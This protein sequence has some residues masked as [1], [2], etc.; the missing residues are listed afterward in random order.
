[1]YKICCVYYLL[2]RLKRGHLTGFTQ[3]VTFVNRT[4]AARGAHDRRLLLRLSFVPKGFVNRDCPNRVRPVMIYDV[5]LGETS[6]TFG[7]K[8]ATAKPYRICTYHTTQ[9]YKH[10]TDPQIADASS[11]KC[12]APPA[13]RAHPLSTHTAHTTRGVARS[14]AEE[15]GR[16]VDDGVAPEGLLHGHARDAHHG[17]APILDLGDLHGVHVLG[18]AHAVDGRLARHERLEREG[19]RRLLRPGQAHRVEAVVAADAEPLGVGLAP[20]L[21]LEEGERPEDDH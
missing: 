14:V 12:T 3:A 5:S 10:E 18:V 19:A 9:Q 20:G 15:E 17:H 2:S 4:Q 8:R 1:M 11:L 6:S 7:A 21:E 13:P 16:L